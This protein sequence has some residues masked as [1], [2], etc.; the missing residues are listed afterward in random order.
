MPRSLITQYGHV[1]AVRQSLYLI[2]GEKNP[3]I[4][5]GVHQDEEIIK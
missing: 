5:V 1:N 4:V 3:R 2:E